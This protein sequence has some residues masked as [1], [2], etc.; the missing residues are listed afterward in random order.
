[1]GKHWPSVRGI[2]DYLG[3]GVDSVYS[4]VSTK[5]MPGH[6]VGRHW[7]FQRNEV[8]GWVGDGGAEFAVGSS[9]V[10]VDAESCAQ[11]NASRNP[12]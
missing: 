10:A 8:D 3:V 12:H 9:F 11:S 7:G 4:W 2:P 5:G 6:R 1:M